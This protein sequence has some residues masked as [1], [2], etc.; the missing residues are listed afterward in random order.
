[1]LSNGGHYICLMVGL[2]MSMVM[3]ERI[4]LIGDSIDRYLVNDWCEFLHKHNRTAE[5]KSWGD[6]SIKYGGQSGVKQPSLICQID[7]NTSI[8]FLH[9]FG[10]SAFGP[11]LWVD[12]RGDPFTATSPRVKAALGF[13][14]DQVG[15]PDRVLLHTLLWDFRPYRSDVVIYE[16]EAKKKAQQTTVD[17]KTYRREKLA[18]IQ[19]D[20]I[21]TLEK[22][23]NERI[24]EIRS[25]IQ[26][27]N[28]SHEVDIGLRTAAWY[29]DGGEF[30]HAMNDLY[31]SMAIK[32]HLT[33]F[34]LDHD[35]WSQVG[36]DYSHVK[37]FFRD[38]HHPSASELVRAAMAL[39]GERRSEQYHVQG[40]GS[41]EMHK[42][43]THTE[44]LETKYE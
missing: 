30:L 16:Y 37:E 28:P 33:L 36:Y 18:L 23:T 21:A 13:Y 39:A 3:A 1:M 31:R 6:H 27:M 29:E 25:V 11:Y 19:N 40:Q 24:K 10:S 43:L 12:T 15:I 38:T 42:E 14:H 32:Q 34:D 5:L 2:Y 22:D 41:I 9:I 17:Y 8:A 7:A 4:L 26:A 20:T 44:G 35:L